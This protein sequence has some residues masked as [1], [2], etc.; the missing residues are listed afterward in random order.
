ME[1]KGEVDIDDIQANDFLSN[2]W[3]EPKLCIKTQIWIRIQSKFSVNAR[4]CT[5]QLDGRQ[6]EEQMSSSFWETQL[7]VISN[8]GFSWKNLFLL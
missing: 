3:N 5:L 6:R 1:G 4:P 8:L 2:P 7:K